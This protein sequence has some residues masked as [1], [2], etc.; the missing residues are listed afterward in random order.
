MEMELT[1][2]LLPAVEYTQSGLIRNVPIRITSEILGF[3]K[4]SLVK[5]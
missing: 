4:K 1:L 3:L 5:L 2:D